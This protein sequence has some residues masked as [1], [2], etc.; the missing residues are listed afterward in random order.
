MDLNEF[1]SLGIFVLIR[2]SILNGLDQCLN[3][4]CGYK[5]CDGSAVVFLVL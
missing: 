2:K 1:R 5:K 4:C 3:E